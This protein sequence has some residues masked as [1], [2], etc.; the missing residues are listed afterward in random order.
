[1]AGRSTKCVCMIRRLISWH[2]E[3]HTHT[4]LQ[5]ILAECGL[6]AEGGPWPLT[7]YKPITQHDLIDL[8]LRWRPLHKGHSVWHISHDQLSGTINHWKTHVWLLSVP[9]LLLW[10]K[11]CH[12]GPNTLSTSPSIAA[13]FCWSLNYSV[14]TTKTHKFTNFISSQLYNLFGMNNIFSCETIVKTRIKMRII[15]KK[16]K[17]MIGPS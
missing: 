3:L 1:M 16:H 6:E 13:S 2:D 5:G 17:I 8:R 15:H 10:T 14:C 12:W 9:L 11:Q 4:H 7:S